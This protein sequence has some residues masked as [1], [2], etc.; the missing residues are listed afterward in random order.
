MKR[1]LK[2]LLIAVLVLGML[3]TAVITAFAHGRGV[4]INNTQ[5]QSLQNAPNQPIPETIT[6]DGYLNDTGWDEFTTVDSASGV[7]NNTVTD[8]EKANSYEYRIRSD[9]E[10]IYGAFRFKGE[11]ADNFK[12]FFKSGTSIVTLTYANGAMTSSEEAVEAPI[13]RTEK[14]VVEFKYRLSNPTTNDIYYYVCVDFAETAS[15][16]HPAIF[17]EEG[18]F[19]SPSNSWDENALKISRNDILGI[20]DNGKLPENTIPE[21]MIIDG[22]FDEAYS[23]NLT[24]FFAPRLGGAELTDYKDDIE[25][26]GLLSFDTVKYSNAHYNYKT[27]PA[28]SIDPDELCF[29][30]DVRM[31]NKAIYGAAVVYDG[32]GGTTAKNGEYYNLFGIYLFKDGNRSNYY[33]ITTKYDSTTRKNTS[34]CTLYDVVGANN[35]G[36][37]TTLTADSVTKVASVYEANEFIKIEFIIDLDDLGIKINS[38]DSNGKI[39]YSGAERVGVTAY[40][41]SGEDTSGNKYHANVTTSY[42]GETSSSAQS[43]GFSFN[44]KDWLGLNATDGFAADGSLDN[45]DFK[46]LNSMD[47]MVYG[48]YNNNGKYTG[49]V[50]QFAHVIESDYEYIYGA[51]LVQMKSGE[52]WSCDGWGNKETEVFSLWIN[53]DLNQSDSAN[54]THVL[55]ISRNG[56]NVKARLQIPTG[57]RDLEV[58]SEEIEAVILPAGGTDGTG[59]DLVR[60]EFKVPLRL[61]GISHDEDI[62][63]AEAA[64]TNAIFYKV[65]VDEDY[66]GES[67]IAYPARN[68][69]TFSAT[70]WQLCGYKNYS[71]LRNWVSAN[72]NFSEEFWQNS[73][74]IEVNNSNADYVNGCDKDISFKYKFYTGY[75]YLY[76]AIEVNRNLEMLGNTYRFT[77]QI[78]QLD[79]N[80][81]AVGTLN[82]AGTPLNGKT[83]S[84]TFKR[85]ND[86]WIFEGWNDTVEV[87]NKDII[88]EQGFDDWSD[89]HLRWSVRTLNGNTY[90]EFMLDYDLYNENR[91]AFEYFV[92]LEEKES[93]TGGTAK[94]LYPSRNGYKTNAAAYSALTSAWNT[95]YQGTADKLGTFIPE[96]IK[97]DGD[98]SDNGW[99]KNG[100]ISVTETVNGSAQSNNESTY[101]NATYGDGQTNSLLTYRYQ[102]RQD[103]EY[104]YVA[105]VLDVEYKVGSFKIDK[106]TGKATTDYFTN[107]FLR[108]WVNTKNSDGTMSESFKKLYEVS[109][110]SDSETVV[111]TRTDEGKNNEFTV[112]SPAGTEYNS[113]TGKITYLYHSLRAAENLSGE[114]KGGNAEQK[115]DP[116]TQIKTDTARVVDLPYVDSCFYGFT[117]EIQENL[118]NGS[119]AGQWYADPQT[120]S[121]TVGNEHAVINSDKDVFDGISDEKGTGAQTIVEFK[122]KL[123]E[124][125]AGYGFEYRVHAGKSGYYTKA[126]K[127]TS[128]RYQLHSPSIYCEPGSNYNFWGINFP[129]WTWHNGIDAYAQWEDIELRNN[130]APVT[131][132]GAKISSDYNGTGTNAIRFGAVYNESYI[133][134]LDGKDEADYW[135]VADMGIVIYPTDDLNGE[136]LTLET[137]GCFYDSAEN[138]VAWQTGKNGWGTNFADYENFVFFVTLYGIPDELL[139]QRL[140]AR[141]YMTFYTASNVGAPYY[142]ATVIRSYNIVDTVTDSALDEVE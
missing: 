7:W 99:D 137:E 19:N 27:S 121:F 141:G 112:T 35:K 18:E 132:L 61:F 140:S 103:G 138:I 38:P 95:E 139:G 28:T 130:Y 37:A 127:E 98:L 134:Y 90:I 30:W 142:D 116:A 16:Y 63:D 71:T 67:R 93:E 42:G 56:E 82:N 12:V 32:I 10:Y 86:E 94:I 65:S 128:I 115:Y 15:L 49:D 111:L 100:W 22:V 21:Y 109:G 47:S 125:D 17:A 118:N 108:I 80:G 23:V 79:E 24:D 53:A 2:T 78:R 110:G 107:P 119:S 72:G 11:A 92:V 34:E 55:K 135:D 40:S 74:F 101:E 117:E 77:I 54:F 60:I 31:D 123:D 68:G 87:N 59:W 136:E 50:R 5:N 91:N 113:G 105:A 45:S 84:F 57:Y 62:T 126:G 131:T 3:P 124:I 88:V 69:R 104:L 52:A 14:N 73:D 120:N 51:A 133:R 4:A 96:N 85:G 1:F 46:A 44:V 70:A 81:N 26:C 48:V 39:T 20:K 89:Q 33:E 66:S 8:S 13:V 64:K 9:Y 83:Q 106:T 43:Y 41:Q 6:V 36:K 25:N 58:G 97:I 102:V 76:G 129:Y 75:E 29:K 122:I 114:A